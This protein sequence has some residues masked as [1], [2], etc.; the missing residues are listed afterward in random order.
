[1]TT[2]VTKMDITSASGDGTNHSLFPHSTTFVIPL[3]SEQ[4]HGAYNGDVLALTGT[5]SGQ[6]AVITD[7]G[8]HSTS[9]VSFPVD[10]ARRH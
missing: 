3:H 6:S 5:G 9:I 8:K 10:S 7:Y 2:N 1:M 4:Q